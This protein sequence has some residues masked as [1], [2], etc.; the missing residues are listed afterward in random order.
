MWEED[1]CLLFSMSFCLSK[2]ISLFVP[3]IFKFLKYTN[4]LSDDVIYST[5]F[6]SN[7][8]KDNSSNLSQKC[9]IPCRTII[10]PV[11]VLYNISSSALLPWQHY[12]FQTSLILGALT[13]FWYLLMVQ[14][15][16]APSSKHINILGWVRGLVKCFSSWKSLKYWNHVGGLKTSELPWQ[17]KFL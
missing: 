13:L 7:M 16:S 8:I 10:L 9:L 5:E 2:W 17:L 14:A 3:E 4:K 11:D 1:W 6:L 15:L 12:G